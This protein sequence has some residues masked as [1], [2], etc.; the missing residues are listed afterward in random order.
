VPA[1][2]DSARTLGHA[3]FYDEPEEDGSMEMPT[4]T[5]LW[6]LDEV[7]S[8]PDD[9]NRY[10]LVHGVQYVTPPLRRGAR[11]VEVTGQLSWHPGSASSPLI[12]NLAE[13]FGV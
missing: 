4:A 11:S 8:L 6:G 7:H 13:I 1:S 3:R 12:I 10:E 5:K 2:S 9:G